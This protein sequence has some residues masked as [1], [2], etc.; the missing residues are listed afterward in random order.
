MG[1]KS[2]NSKC[3]PSD[4]DKGLEKKR[5]AVER[6]NGEECKS[7]SPPQT[8][9]NMQYNMQQQ[10]QLPIQ[11]PVNHGQTHNVN[12]HMWHYNNPQNM[13]S[14]QISY[15]Q[16]LNQG[17]T[18]YNLPPPLTPNTTQTVTNDQFSTM[19]ARFDELENKLSQLDCI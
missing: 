18:V 12:G 2:N 1:R 11:T 15:T 4:K 7:S 9:A 19:M 10:Q 5:V 3:Y 13:A 16:A 8:A 14:P 6:E 17:S